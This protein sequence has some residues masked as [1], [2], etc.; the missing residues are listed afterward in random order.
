MRLKLGDLGEDWQLISF[1]KTTQT[2]GHGA[3][4]GCDHDDRRV[5]PIGR[6][7]RCYE[8]GDAGAVLPNANAVPSRHPGKTIGHVAGTLFVSN[9]DKANAS[10]L[11]KVQRVHVGGAHD[12]ENVSDALR[13]QGFHEGLRRRHFD[14]ALGDAAINLGRL[15]GCDLRNLCDL[16]RLF[17]CFGCHGNLSNFETDDKCAEKGREPRS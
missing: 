6:G 3:G 14:F 5:R 4:F 11:E 13:D 8:I 10:G 17:W 12:A 2:Q 16:G 1:L 7:D 15:F 9:R